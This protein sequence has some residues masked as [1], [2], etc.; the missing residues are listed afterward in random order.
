M[1]IHFPFSSELSSLVASALGTVAVTHLTQH[2][3]D[4]P[5]LLALLNNFVKYVFAHDHLN[6]ARL[7]PYYIATMTELESKD[8]RSWK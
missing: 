4:H 3:S 2:H 8:E 7:T 1:W 5:A 6:C